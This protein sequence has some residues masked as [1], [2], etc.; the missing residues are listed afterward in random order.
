MGYLPQPEVRYTPALSIALQSCAHECSM[1]LTGNDPALGPM[2]R[3]GTRSRE[4]PRVQ[5]R[6]L[7]L[8][9]TKRCNFMMCTRLLPDK[10]YGITFTLVPW[11]KHLIATTINLNTHAMWTLAQYDIEVNRYD[12]L[13]DDF[14]ASTKEGGANS[15]SHGIAARCKFYLKLTMHV[16]TRAVER[17]TANG[18]LDPRPKRGAPASNPQTPAATGRVVGRPRKHNRNENFTKSIADAAFVVHEW[19]LRAEKCRRASNTLQTD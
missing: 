18:G 10:T 17:I 9:E 5:P 4:L 3:A 8:R 1:C 6:C 13:L 19:L 16:I 2:P 11:F 7:L 15:S 12:P 14:R